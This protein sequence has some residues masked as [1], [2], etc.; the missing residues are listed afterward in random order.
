MG[1][2]MTTACL[3]HE[4]TGKDELLAIACK[5]ADFLDVAFRKPTAEEARHAICPSHSMG[6][7][8][9]YRTTGESRYLDLAKRLIQMRDLVVDGGDDNQDRVPFVQQS[10]AIGHAVRATFYPL[11]PTLK[12]TSTG[13]PPATHLTNT[14]YSQTQIQ[15]KK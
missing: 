13:S 15:E 14:T 9:L 11:A 3:H 8:D 4:V 6:I 10:E 7:I 1:H 2:L 5:A 12:T